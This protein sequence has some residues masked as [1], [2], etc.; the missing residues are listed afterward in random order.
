VPKDW[1][2]P[3]DPKLKGRVAQCAPTRSS[4]SHATCEVTLRRDGDEKDWAWLKRLAGN[5][6]I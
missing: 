1:D 5:T 2:D 3:L 4:S 6:G